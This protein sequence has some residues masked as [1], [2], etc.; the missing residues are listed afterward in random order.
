MGM[1]GGISEFL[2]KIIKRAR[3]ADGKTIG[4]DGKMI[5]TKLAKDNKGA[6]VNHIVEQYL[7]QEQLD[8]IPSEFNIVDKDMIEEVFNREIGKIFGK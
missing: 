4:Q 5:K 3:E 7:K 2:E 1:S 8:E 6:W